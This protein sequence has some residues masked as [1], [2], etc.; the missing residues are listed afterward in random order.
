MKDIIDSHV[1]LDLIARKHPAKIQW[2]KENRCGVVSWAYLERA[3]SVSELEAGLDGHARSIRQHASEGLTCLYLSGIHPRSI[4]P[5]LESEQIRS[6]LEA[7]LKD[8]LCRGIGEIGLE[9]GDLREQEVFIT[10]LELART[11]LKP[12]HVIGIHTPR[13]NKPSL[14]ITTLAILDGFQDMSASIVVDHCTIETIGHVLEAGFRAGVTLSPAKTSWDELKQIVA[15][16]GDQARR[17]MCNTDSGSEFYDDV[18]RFGCHGDLSE[19]LRERIFHLNAARFY[20]I[21][22]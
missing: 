17:I 9:T 15:L 4:P 8:P 18:V 2:L 19:T 14:T 16:H 20:S 3:D 22:V 11:L 12:G 1:H 7:R 21:P 10:Q 5:D 6:I 13:S